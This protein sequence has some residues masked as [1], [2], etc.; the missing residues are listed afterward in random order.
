MANPYNIYIT[1]DEYDAAAAN[2]ISANLLNQRVR[3]HGWDKARAISTPPRPIVSRKRWLDLAA[4][5]GI[6]Y[7]TMYYRVRHMGW[8]WDRAATTPPLSRADVVER[9]TSGMERHDP[10]MLELANKNGIP[11]TTYRSRVRRNGWDPLRAATT[12]TMTWQESMA[13]GAAARKKK[14]EIR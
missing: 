11:L 13:L 4:Q 9:L 5:N 12:P 6:S 14:E 2:G 10:E 7:K 8:D 1:P 3:A